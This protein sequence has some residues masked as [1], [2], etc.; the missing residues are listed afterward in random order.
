MLS[1]NYANLKY[2]ANDQ[3]NL[4]LIGSGIQ[5][6]YDTKAALGVQGITLVAACDLYL[7]RLD[8]AKE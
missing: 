7:G 6:I 4:A 8:R 2:G 5:G 3:I 1:R